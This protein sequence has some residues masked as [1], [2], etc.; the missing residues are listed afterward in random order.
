MTLWHGYLTV[1][2]DGRSQRASHKHRENI[3]HDHN[4]IYPQY[5]GRFQPPPH[6]TCLS[7]IHQPSFT[8]LSTLTYK[9]SQPPF[10]LSLQPLAFPPFPLESDTFSPPPS[11]RYKPSPSLLHLHLQHP[12]STP[13]SR[14]RFRYHTN[15]LSLFPF[16]RL[17][18]IENLPCSFISVCS[19]LCACFIHLL[20]YL[21]NSSA[22]CVILY[23]IIFI[24][25][26]LIYFVFPL[27]CSALLHSTLLLSYL[28]S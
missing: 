17:T 7:T 8:R 28:V 3:S 5:D 11:S 10:P 12:I 20:I 24:L 18:P 21:S 13:R 25:H 6:D 1:E 19:R 22:R 15:P 27:L 26:T 9:H 2:I 4:S 23:Y 14:S 16:Y